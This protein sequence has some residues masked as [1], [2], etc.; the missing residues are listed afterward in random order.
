MKQGQR[1]VGTASELPL[2]R[3]AQ[4]AVVAHIRHVYTQYDRLLRLTS[5][6]EARASVEEPTLAKLVQWRG[7]DENGKTVLEDVFREVIVI[8]D[9]EDDDSVIEE[10]IDIAGGNRD[11]SIE[12]VSSN[13]L[14]GELDMQ[15]VNYSNPDLANNHITRDLSGDEAPS[16]FR[17]V[18][19]T[20][21]RDPAR[22]KNPDRRGFNRY[23]AWDRARDRYRDGAYVADYGS[24]PRHA[25]DDPVSRA[26][27]VSGLEPSRSR[28]ENMEGMHRNQVNNIENLPTRPLD[29]RHEPRVQLERVRHDNPMN[30][31]S[32]TSHVS[33]LSFHL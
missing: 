32:H 9:D 14:V 24:T 31:N 21:R 27:P 26:I 23:Q 4:L 30:P 19:M 5:F 12:L 29:T 16:G 18:P 2:A 8:S 7:D 15:P 13:A 25:V 10:D 17:F 33:F 28:L 22:K 11:S 6:Q 3:R 20:H 1:K